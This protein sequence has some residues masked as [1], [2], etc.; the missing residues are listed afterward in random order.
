MKFRRQHPLGPS[1]IA[2]FYCAEAR[3]AVELDGSIHNSDRSHWADGIRHLQIQLAGVRVLR[4]RNENVVNDLEGVLK[5]IG[6]YLSATPNTGVDQEWRLAHELKSGDLLVI[7]ELGET[8]VIQSVDY[9]V[10]N[11]TVFDLT[12][13]EDHSFV[14]EAGVAHNHSGPSRHDKS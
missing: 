9:R 12:V 6:E 5:E 10:V 3:L 11:E 2:D 8:A 4:F 7:N 1:Y 13:D 14:T